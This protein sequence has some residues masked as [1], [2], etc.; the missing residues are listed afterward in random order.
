MSGISPLE[1][2]VSLLCR[3]RKGSF[4]IREMCSALM[5]MWPKNM[6]NEAEREKYAAN[7]DPEI[8]VSHIVKL[9]NTGTVSEQAGLS[10]MVIGM[11]DIAMIGKRTQEDWDKILKTKMKILDRATKEGRSSITDAMHQEIGFIPFRAKEWLAHI[12]E[13]N[14]I[15]EENLSTQAINKWLQEALA[16]ERSEKHQD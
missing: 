10:S 4:F 12:E 2:A 8:F 11:M 13:W 3:S 7:K 16:E 5:S 14:L 9:N 1:H 6:L 15:Y